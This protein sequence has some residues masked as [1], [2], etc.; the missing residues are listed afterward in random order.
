MNYSFNDVLEVLTESLY[1]CIV[2]KEYQDRLNRLTL[3]FK[4]ENFDS[5]T[6]MKYY[7]YKELYHAKR[8]NILSNK[9]RDLSNLYK[10]YEHDRHQIM[11]STNDSIDVRRRLRMKYDFDRDRILEKYKKIMSEFIIDYRYR[12]ETMNLKWVYIKNEDLKII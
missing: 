11:F 3:Q 2:D 7:R 8:K 5:M 1:D 9:D 4:S 12:A 6:K 10:K